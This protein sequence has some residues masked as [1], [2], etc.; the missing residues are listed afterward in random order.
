MKFYIDPPSTPI[1][2][3]LIVDDLMLQLNVA[4]V[5]SDNEMNNRAKKLTKKI[6]KDCDF[7]RALKRDELRG[8]FGLPPG[9][10]NAA[11]DSIVNETS[12]DTYIYSRPLKIVGNTISGGWVL[13][14]GSD[15]FEKMK[16]MSTVIQDTEKGA[17]LPWLRW[18]LERGNSIIITNFRVKFQIGKGRSGFAHMIPNAVIGYRVPPQFAGTDHDN[19]FTKA[20]IPRLDEYSD[21][22]LKTLDKYAP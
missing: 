2:K 21:I 14:I 12:S 6:I 8:S 7:I 19:W 20:I 1:V 11:I 22:I 5:A 9:G 10:Y 16:N 13:A 3:K 17:K 15:L 18:T 4:R